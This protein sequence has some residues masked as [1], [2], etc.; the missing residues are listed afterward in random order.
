MLIALWRRVLA[1]D[2]STTTCAICGNDFDRG[3]VFSVVF[4]DGGQELG[5][6]CPTCLDY[7]NRRKEDAEDPTMDNW[8]ARYWPTLEDLQEA[9]RR[10]P[11]PMFADNDAY[12]A[13]SGYDPEREDELLQSSFIWRMK[14][15]KVRR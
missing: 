11:E 4:G 9:R 12:D 8:P 2:Y 6:M 14:P 13:G 1:S 3:N 10:Y 5:E 15:E 7:L